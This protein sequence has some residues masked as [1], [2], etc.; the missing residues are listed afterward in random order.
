MNWDTLSVSSVRFTLLCQKYAWTA[1]FSDQN[2]A[3]A[4]D[5]AMD[6]V[7]MLVDTNGRSNLPSSS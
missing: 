4:T 1:T 3:W 6:H 5:Y 7:L 2:N